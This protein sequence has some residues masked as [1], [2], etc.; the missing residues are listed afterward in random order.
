MS[1]SILGCLRLDAASIRSCFALRSRFTLTTARSIHKSCNV[2]KPRGVPNKSNK[3]IENKQSPIA[4]AS[5]YKV[6]HDSEASVIFDN[7][8]KIQHELKEEKELFD[9]FEGIN[10]QRGLSGVFD[11][12]ELVELLQRENAR[13]I[14]VS[15]VPPECRFVEHICI[16]TSR[17]TKHMIAMV[18]FIRK[19]YKRKCNPSDPIPLTEGKTSKDWMALDMGNIALHIFSHSLRIEYDLEQLWSVGPEFDSLYNAPS[20]DI[21]KLLERHSRHLGDLKPAKD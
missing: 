21:I 17:S 11:I 20:D 6:F 16:V 1:I 3:N 14:F 18:E 19:V 5:K 4:L 13:D 9:E 15:S 2:L 7:E 10:L 8:E 12:E